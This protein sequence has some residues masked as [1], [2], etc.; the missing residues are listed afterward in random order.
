AVAR[1]DH[2]GRPLHAELGEQC[3]LDALARGVASVQ[4]LD[5]GAAVDERE[6]AGRST[7]R[8]AER[9]GDLLCSQ[10]AQLRHRD[11]R[12]ERADRAG[13]VKA[14][15]AQVWRARAGEA[16]RDLIARDDRLDEL[17]ARDRALVPDTE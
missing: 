8:D 6:Q 15:L 4:A 5:V 13:R 10:A 2:V 16:D 3:G 17:R 12:A 14:A 1:L 7:P 9:I 11:S